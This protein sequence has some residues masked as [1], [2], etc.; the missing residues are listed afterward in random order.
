M[1]H[2]LTRDTLFLAITR[3]PMKWGVPWEGFKYN[4]F[5]SMAC[6]MIFGSPL[7]CLLLWPAVHVGMRRMCARDHNFFRVLNLHFATRA[8]AVG[9]A[10]RGGST[11]TALPTLRPAAREMRVSV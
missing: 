5:G 1:R 7:W 2:G 11:L 6:G 8:L 10:E 3:P 4:L 9:V